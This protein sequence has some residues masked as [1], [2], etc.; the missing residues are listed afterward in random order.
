MLFKVLGFGILFYENGVADYN[1]CQR[2]R[3]SYFTEML[4]DQC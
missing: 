3:R 4:V 2:G 1:R